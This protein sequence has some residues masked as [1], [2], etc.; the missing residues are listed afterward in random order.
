MNNL[1]SLITDL[2]I[3]LIF[4]CIFSVLCKILH[5][6]VVLGYIIAGFIAGHNFSFLPNVAPESIHTWAEIGVIFLLFGMGLEFSFKK[7]IKTGKSGLKSVLFETITLSIMGFCVG[8]FLL[9]WSVADSLL[10]GAMLIMSSTA[11]IVKTFN[12]LSLTKEKFTS[13]VFGILIFE[14]LFAIII[15]V[16]L[17]TLANAKEIEG[18]SILFLILKLLFFVIIWF[19]GG[20]YLIPT[21][22][23]TLKRWL[24]EETLLIVSLGLC[25]GLVVFATSV[26]FSSALGAFVMGSL[27][28]ETV[29]QERIER[30][31]LPIK[32]FFGA[33][34]FVSVGMMV[35]PV[36]ILSNFKII[37]LL[38]T[39][40]IAG[41]MIFTT[42][43]IRLSGQS[44]KTS[45]QSGFSLAQMGEFAFI[46]ASVG[47]SLKVTSSFIYPIVI[48]VS[49]ITTFTT[50]YTIRLALPFYRI[51]ESILPKRWLDHLNKTEDHRMKKPTS[52]WGELLKS[53]LLY[54]LIFLT[55]CTAIILISFSIIYPLSLKILSPM[56]AN[57]VVA[58]LT[59]VAL[60]PIVLGMIHNRGKQS[61]LFL[62]LWSEEKYNRLFLTLLIGLRY[63][64]ALFI[65]FIVL[66]KFFAVPAFALFIVA[67]VVFALIF[68][69]KGVMKNYWRLESR[70][71]KNFN[72]RQIEQRKQEYSLKGE[73]GDTLHA[74]DNSHWIDRHIYISSFEII[75]GCEFGNHTLKH[76]ALRSKHSILLLSVQRGSNQHNF[77][78]GDFVL[79]EKDTIL[80]CGQIDYLQR[81]T[82]Q[83]TKLTLNFR[84][85]KPLAEFAM[86]QE[87][88]SNSKIKCL[89]FIVNKNSSWIGKNLM[90]SKIGQRS[91]CLVIGLERD[92]RPIVNPSSHLTFKCNDMI[93]VMGDEKS[94]YK[95]LESNFF[96]TTIGK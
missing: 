10:L 23:K 35:D 24:N 11:I 94:L 40:S 81:L 18:L 93:W 6:P 56:V 29:E 28:A 1:P 76:L 53:Y 80:V 86:Q 83:F 55:I 90:D 69:S 22:L 87:Q 59:F 49:V 4:A 74:L 64:V 61:F 34:F 66:N 30:I 95:L 3:I 9:R 16:L 91:Q 26:G 25:F 52:A 21:L 44:L 14:D 39:C 19:V 70:F 84:Q 45:I 96:T 79:Q 8:K 78:D 38:S 89:T 77:P 47:M 5:Q 2:A 32:D 82:E 36:I 63:M 51:L 62:S 20:I 43:G 48:A 67:V 15:M 13:L 42:T 68:Q 65:V 46:V 72:Q 17:S 85:T 88:V 60:S 12:D 7:L 75:K 92:G 31:T 71:V 27:L 73:N 41:K 50:P 58:A 57:I 33:I 37:L 54:L